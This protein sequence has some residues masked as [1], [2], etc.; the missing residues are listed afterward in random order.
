MTI[1]EWTQRNRRD[2]KRFGKPLSAKARAHHLSAMST[3]FRDIQE[4][5]WIPRRFDQRRCFG[6]PRSLRALISP[7]PR[8]LAD[9]V[10]AKLLWAGLNLTEV[11]LTRSFKSTK[12]YYPV[13]MVKA[14]AMVWLFGGLRVDEIW[15]LRIG[16]TR[17]QWNKSPEVSEAICNLDVPV[18]KTSR[19]FTKPVD[20]IVGEVVRAWE[21]ERP[22]QPSALDEKT[23]ELAHFLFMFRSARI[24]PD[25]LNR[26]LIPTLCRKAGLPPT[27]ARGR[28]TSH[29]ARST[30]ASQL[31][32]AKEPMSLFELQKW[33]GHEWANSTQY[34]LDI[35]P[36]KLANSYRDASYFARNVRAIEVLIDRDVVKNGTA[37]REPWMY[38]D[39]GHGY[40]T[41]DFFEQCKFRMVC[42]KCSF[43][44]PKASSEAQLLEG[45]SNLMRL[46]QGIPL[47]D[48]QKTNAP[49]LA[50]EQ[51]LFMP[52]VRKTVSILDSHHVHSL[53]RLLNLVRQHF[54]Q[55]NV[56]DL[57]L[58]LHLLQ[59]AQ[60]LFQRRSRVD[61]VQLVKFDP[62]QLQ[63]PQAH[64]HALDQVARPS[65]VLRLRRPL[66]CNPAL[67]RDHQ[68]RRVRVKRL[69]NQP[70][71]NLRSV[72]VRGVNQV[73]AQLNR[74]PQHAPRSLRVV[75]LAPCTRPHQ[76]HRSVTH[77]VHRQVAAN[78]ESSA[79]CRVRR[80]G[81]HIEF[82]FDAPPLAV[83][84][85]QRIAFTGN[86]AA[87]RCVSSRQQQHQKASGKSTQ[88]ARRNR[89]EDP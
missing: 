39:L 85:I 88:S 41:F 29:R 52:P 35:S 56:P 10:W 7:N 86:K 6:A 59:R 81:L 48:R 15:R 89:G 33:L 1:G 12:H 54:A 82:V 24:A 58:L 9:D 53:L 79:R 38:Y 72:C 50:I 43:Y 36:T 11:D 77:P 65:H 14:L 49:T 75:R 21:A 80:C 69:R 61:A 71:G 30:I 17:E 60:R 19:A 78:Q 64:L 57:S 5:E 2:Q 25:Y 73:H 46:R 16:C 34:Y 31:F 26:T 45:K 55:P 83:N 13:A 22:E 70:L 23:G 74:P 20:Q 40:C 37:A 8:I 67:R 27:D 66:P 68:P 51:R 76:A 4:W 42:A 44:R 28:I 84:E 62:F 3:F 18:N 32:N 87:P 47:T 63:P